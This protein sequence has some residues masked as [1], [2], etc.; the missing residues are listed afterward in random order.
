MISTTIGYNGVHN[1]FRHP[2][3]FSGEMP[4]ANGDFRG[5]SIEKNGDFTGDLNIFTTS[6]RWVP[7]GTTDENYSL[8]HNAMRIW[9][10]SQFGAQH[11]IF[12]VGI[13]QVTMGFNTWSSMTTG[14]FRGT[15]YP[16]DDW[17]LPVLAMKPMMRGGNSRWF[18]VLDLLRHCWLYHETGK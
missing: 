18:W 12:G 1:I 17:K 10:T 4:A 11:D 5:K 14:W 6:R 13:P 3:R 15:R 9:E 7:H 2:H 16:H 8:V